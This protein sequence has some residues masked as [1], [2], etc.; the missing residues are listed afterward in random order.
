MLCWP[1]PGRTCSAFCSSLGFIGGS[2][3]NKSM[4]RRAV[5]AQR[6]FPLPRLRTHEQNGAAPRRTAPFLVSVKSLASEFRR[7][8]WLLF[9]CGFLSLFP[10]FL[11]LLLGD[12]DSESLRVDF[13]ESASDPQRVV[14]L[15][16][17]R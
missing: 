1:W 17:G 9:A 2:L 3:S 11:L 4:T 16:L 6:D 5:K 10:R 13:E 14:I 15:T 7:R 8:L 12:I